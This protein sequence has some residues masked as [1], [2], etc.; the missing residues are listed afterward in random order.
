MKRSFL[1]GNSRVCGFSFLN[2]YWSHN[3]D[4]QPWRNNLNCSTR[5][6]GYELWITKIHLQS[7]A[8]YL[9]Y[10][11]SPIKKRTDAEYNKGLR[12]FLFSQTHSPP[13]SK[14]SF[15]ARCVGLFPLYI[16]H[17]NRFALTDISSLYHFMYFSYYRSTRKPRWHY[18]YP[19]FVTFSRPLHG[20]CP[21][22]KSPLSNVI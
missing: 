6:I 22:F 20:K 18:E 13:P 3:V 11:A 16:Y 9:Q 7:E 15:T 2:I 5:H 8:A 21:D 1:T 17:S 4:V 10:F 19:P 14:T 12:T